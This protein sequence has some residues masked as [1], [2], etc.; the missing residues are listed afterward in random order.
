M[1]ASLLAMF[2]STDKCVC[3]SYCS[4]LVI[5]R[6]SIFSNRVPAVTLLIASYFVF[7]LCWLFRSITYA[8]STHTPYD[9]SNVFAGRESGTMYIHVL[10]YL[11]DVCLCICPRLVCHVGHEI[12]VAHQYS[13]VGILSFPVLWLA[14]AGGTVFWVIGATVVTV[15]VHAALRVLDSDPDELFLQPADVTVV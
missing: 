5:A 6:C 10:I 1:L 4:F 3:D 13:A 12:S 15:L 11:T 9:M 2:S 8:R 14:G 7:C